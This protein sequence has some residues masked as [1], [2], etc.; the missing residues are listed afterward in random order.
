MIPEIVI[1]E[2]LT[3]SDPPAVDAIEL[4]NPTAAAADIGGWFLTDDA[5][6]PTKFRIPNGTM[7]AAG[8]Y[9]VFDETQFNP[10]PGSNNSFALNSAGDQIYLFSGDANT[11]LT[12]YSHGFAFGAAGSFKLMPQRLQ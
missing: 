10:T 2:A 11:N 4:Y 6:L 1:N 3:H 9:L 7:I 8:G 12:G 5:A